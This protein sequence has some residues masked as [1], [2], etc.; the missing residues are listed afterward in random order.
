MFDATKPL[1]VSSIRIDG[2]TQS[3][4]RIIQETVDDYAVAMAEG[5][6]FP[7]IVVF[8]D[9]KEY[10]LADGFHRYH[11]TRKNKRASITA[12]IRDRKSTRLNSSHT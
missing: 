1:N 8:F 11:A 6:E 3:R 12:N 2:G 5:A 10:W 7:P 4:S 9:G